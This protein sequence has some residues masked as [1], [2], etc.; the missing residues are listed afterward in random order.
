M[1]GAGMRV[2]NP[3]VRSAIESGQGLR[4][5]LGCGLRPREGF[6]GVDQAPLPTTDILADLNEPLKDLPDHSVVEV[7]SRH[8]LEHVRDLLQLVSELHRVCR[9]DARIEIVV[10]HF[11]NPY[12]YSD[13]THVRPF[14]LYTFFY[15]AD[16]EDQPRRKVPSFYSSQRF[17]VESV[18]IQLLR[19]RALGKPLRSALQWW[20]NRSIDHLDWYERTACR[21]SP[22]ESIRYVLRP[23]PATALG[24][25]S[26]RAA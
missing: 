24:E 8:T 21:L 9:P 7:F 16:E 15:F 22:A 14:G 2:I 10:P 12:Y 1:K 19:R 6:F 11:S 17:R 25:F 23:K 13:P 4:L 26:A 18:S 3:K 20:I 5:N